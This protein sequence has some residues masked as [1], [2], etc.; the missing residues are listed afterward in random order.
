MIT[1]QVWD[2]LPEKEKQKRIK[3]FETQLRWILW[4]R[5][6]EACIAALQ[7]VLNQVAEGD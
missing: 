6:K 5:D 2:A 3:R 1:E 7:S 4:E